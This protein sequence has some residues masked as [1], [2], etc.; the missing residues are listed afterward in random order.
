VQQLRDARAAAS[1]RPATA[2]GK[3]VFVTGTGGFVGYHVALA[4]RA[5]G[6]GVLGLDNFNGH[7]PSGLKRTRAGTLEQA[8]VITLEADLNDA[9]A[10]KAATELCNFT[11]VLHLAAQPGVRYAL[12]DPDAY[13]KSNVGG[14]VSVLERVRKLDPMP[15][16]VYA[17]SSSVYGTNTKMPFSEEDAVDSPASLYAA[18]KRED[19]LLAHTYNHL[20]HIPLTGLRFFT[21]YGPY[22]RP[23][24]ALF[25][26]A[27]RILK[28]EPVTV[29]T[30]PD[31]REMER[32]FTY[33]DDIVR[34][35]LGALDNVRLSRSAL[36]ARNMTVSAADDSPP[37]LY[38]LGNEHPATV[39]KLLDLLEEF[40]GK[41]AVREYVPA[42]NTGDVFRTFANVSLARAELGYQPQIP[43]REGV[44]RFVGWY[45]E[46]YKDG[47]DAAMLRY[48]A[49]GA[50]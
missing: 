34:G 50:V 6:D 20:F 9:D 22:G 8:G 26:F 16:V 36:K 14:F 30:G 2:N 35:C 11:H 41:R 23:D 10:L 40:M 42:S 21:V 49:D 4:L 29:Y 7:Y 3:I 47:L 33:I 5:R 44:R 32:D 13:V 12:K 18:T 19:E 45:Q 38:N 39:S 43:L 17:S 24:M 37:K 27:N 1:C 48:S 15:S 25:G 31:G 28:G 46:F